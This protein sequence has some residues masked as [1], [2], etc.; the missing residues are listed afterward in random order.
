MMDCITGNRNFL[1]H[2][3]VAAADREADRL[4]EADRASARVCCPWC[5]SVS[6]WEQWDRLDVRVAVA[7]SFLAFVMK[8]AT[9]WGETIDWER[10]DWQSRAERAANWRDTTSWCL[11]PTFYRRN[12][13]ADHLYVPCWRCQ[14]PTDGAAEMS[15]KEV[16]R[17]LD[18]GL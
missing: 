1:E 10:D 14:P 9:R 3:A 17:W 2:D 8:L 12:G 5:G 16:Q 6:G 13:D 15:V 7:C 4:T 11:I 18:G